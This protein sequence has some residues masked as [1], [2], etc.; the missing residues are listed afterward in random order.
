MIPDNLPQISGVAEVDT[1]V[2]LYDDASGANLCDA[3]ANSENE[4]QCQLVLPLAEGQNTLTAIATD[5][6]GND[7]PATV[8]TIMVDTTSPPAP[9]VDAP[10]SS[11]T[12]D[13]GKPELRGT[14]EPDSTITIYDESNVELCTNN[15]E[16]C[17]NRVDPAGNW[18]CI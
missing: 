1:M 16:L 8:H 18:D 15:V 6:A 12:I 14:A 10:P 4:W 5:R 3:T 9:I 13:Q 7:S 2:R 17:T 11:A